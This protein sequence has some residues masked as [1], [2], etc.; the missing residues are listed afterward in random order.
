MGIKRTLKGAVKRLPGVQVAKLFKKPK[1]TN[2][3]ARSE[4]AL[5]LVQRPATRQAGAGQISY[6]EEKLE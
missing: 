2:D 4:A 3:D 5:S 6:T 1:R